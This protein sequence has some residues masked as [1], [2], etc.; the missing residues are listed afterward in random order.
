MDL[1][2]A[3]AEITRLQALIQTKRPRPILLDLEQYDG[4]EMNAY[5]Q[6]ESKLYAKLQVDEAAL[7]GPYERLW[8]AFDRL[9]RKMA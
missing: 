3:M 4:E 8:Y 1:Q 5:P 9:K 6:F 2:Q 7:G